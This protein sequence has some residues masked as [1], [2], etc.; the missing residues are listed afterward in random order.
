VLYERAGFMQPRCA[1]TS[2]AL[3]PMCRLGAALRDGVR[4]WRRPAVER[5]GVAIH[6][7]RAAAPASI[8]DA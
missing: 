1:K 6:S 7:L 8:H 2:A 4:A 5:A 3:P